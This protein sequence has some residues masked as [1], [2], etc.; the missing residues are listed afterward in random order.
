MKTR[1]G[2]KFINVLIVLLLIVSL[3]FFTR[4]PVKAADPVVSVTVTPSD[5]TPTVGDTITVSINIDMSASGG[6]ALGSYTGTLEWD[7]AV[8]SY[9]NIAGAPPTGFVGFNNTSSIATGKITFNGAKATGATGSVVVLVA[10]FDVIG[11]GAA[12]LTLAFSPMSA[13]TSFGNLLLILSITQANVIAS[14][15]PCYALTLTHTGSGANPVASPSNSTGCST[16]SYTAGQ[17]ISLTGAVPNSGW[18]IAAWTGTNNN[19]ST[20]STNT[21]TMPASAHTASV[22][23]TQIPPA[24]YALTLSH[25][26][27]GTNPTASPANSSGC[28]AGQYTSGQAISLTGAVADSG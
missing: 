11:S 9:E 21:I 20:A 2:Y 10:T 16:G 28:T 22:T 12:D 24:C 8:L 23:Y 25:T 13:A 26:G 5:T 3:G 27:N 15:V 19:S 14:P 6:Q 1:L 18:Q 7:P 17:V 4:S